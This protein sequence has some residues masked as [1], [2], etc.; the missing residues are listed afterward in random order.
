MKLI[1]F[2]LMLLAGICITL[3][4]H[5]QC[6]NSNI[7]GTYFYVLGGS[8]KSGTDTLSYSELG[9]VVADGRGGL[10][11][12]TTSSAGGVLA[13]MPVT[14]TYSLQPNCSGTATATTSIGTTQFSIQLVNGGNLVLAAVTA[15]PVSALAEGRFYRAANATGSQCGN[16]SLSGSYG[17]LLSGGSYASGVRSG[18]SNVAQ[19]VFDGKGGL[20]VSSVVTSGNLTGVPLTGTGTYSIAADCSGVAQITTPAGVVNFNI[21]RVTGGTLLILENDSNTTISGTANPQQLLTVLPQFV[22]GG[23]W[24]SALYFT[25]T[26]STPVSFVVNFTTD[27]GTPMAL[28]GLGFSRNVSIAPFSTAIIEAQNTGALTQGY[29]SFTLPSG[30][31]GYGVFRQTVAGR[32][33]QEAV[34]G[35]KSATSTSDSLTWDDTNFTTAVAM[36]NP[37]TVS[38]TVTIT[39]WDTAGNVIGTSTQVLPPGTKIENS[40]RGF[41]G[42]AGVAGTRGSALFTVQAGNISVLGLRFGGSAFTSIPTTQQQ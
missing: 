20:T 28:P 1:K 26:T 39:A 18:Y 29:A 17:G 14:G 40:L 31:N 23:G 10:T 21:A 2:S 5:A 6:N 34:A 37:S 33:D 19:T 13:T 9:K 3:P 4:A 25:N 41:L 27:A 16:G 12:Q 7:N 36:V 38:A 30:V 22:F 42:L 15:S 35:F 32:P 8:V 24:Y 11:G